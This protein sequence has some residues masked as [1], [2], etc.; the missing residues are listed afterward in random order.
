MSKEINKKFNIILIAGIFS[1]ICGIALLIL[2]FIKISNNDINFPI[3]LTIIPLTIFYFFSIIP[4]TP[5]ILATDF[6]NDDVNNSKTFWALLSLFVLGPIALILFVIVNRKKYKD[7]ENINLNNN[8]ELNNDSESESGA[9]LWAEIRNEKIKRLRIILLIGIFCSILA[10]ILAVLITVLNTIDSDIYEIANSI[11]TPISLIIVMIW[12]VL[13]ITAIIFIFSTDFV[14]DE[15]NENKMLWGSYSIVLLIFTPIVLICFSLITTKKL[16]KIRRID[17]NSNP[18]IGNTFQ[19]PAKFKLLKQNIGNE[20]IV[21][22]TTLRVKDTEEN[23]IFKQM[24]IL[25][26]TG[27]STYIA[28]L[29]FGFIL[30]FGWGP[31]YLLYNFG[32][33]IKEHAMVIWIPVIIISIINIISSIWILSSDFEN[34]DVNKRKI[35]WGFLSLFILGSLGIIIFVGSNISYYDTIKPNSETEINIKQGVNNE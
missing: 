4:F 2:T 21:E 8:I 33:I 34:D 27:L 6:K 25:F 26:W 3:E 16:M 24:K 1:L 23:K 28:G 12:I 35:V 30:I 5:Y 9:I 22:S 13:Q 17:T 31:L 29:V 32:E 19:G 10:I 20:N 18:M 14:N 7:Y 15:I 11:I